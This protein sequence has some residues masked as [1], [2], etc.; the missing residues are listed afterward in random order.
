MVRILKFAVLLCCLFAANELRATT[1]YV[2]YAGGSDSNDGQ[3]KTSPWQYAPGMKSCSSVCNSATINPGD[4]IILKGG[5][6]WPNSA[7]TW[8]IPSSSGAS[9]YVGV[10][11]SWYVGSAW[12]RPILNSGKAVISGSGSLS[13]VMISMFQNT[14]LDNFEITG[15]YWDKQACSPG[16]IHCVMIN[17]GQTNGQLI[18]NLYIHGW[19]HAGNSPATS[20]GVAQAV[21]TGTGGSSVAHDI[22]ID[23]TDV[24][25]DYSLTAFYGGPPDLY[26]I[27]CKQVSS[28]FIVAYADSVHDNHIEDIGRAYCNPVGFGACT[29]ENGFE[30]NGDTGLLFYNNVIKNVSAGLAIWIAPNPNYTAYIFNNVV[31]QTHNGSNVFDLARPVYS[32]SHCSTGSN[33]QGYCNNAGN[34]VVYNNTIE[35]GDDSSQ[36]G[37]QMGFP[38]GQSFLFQNN[39][40]ILSSTSGAGCKSGLSN[41]T[42][43]SSNTL[44]TL[45]TANKQGYS[46]GEAFAFSPKGSGAA[47]IG[48]GIIQIV[49]CTATTV[50]DPAAGTA[51]LKDST[52]GVSYNTANHSVSYPAR[53]N[54]LRG[55]S[56]DSGAY[57]YS[58]STSTTV[59]PPTGL[60]TTVN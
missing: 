50:I 33:A 21:L 16:I 41:C 14:T 3:S 60:V 47:T 44:Q 35:N 27:W 42:F 54:Q 53:S 58:T 28:C 55:A 6:T 12:T 23:G 57:E 37:L 10:D 30:D 26:N 13:N 36:S 43:D 49:L 32:P 48:A 39:H 40:F 18:E 52:Y 24:P 19:T 2:D 45:A 46:S 29:H 15:F 59:Q 9:I 34:F 5:V 56:W 1:Y 17:M 25:G 7:F 8:S 51:C 22:V 4:S 11:K 31:F 38:E 20:S